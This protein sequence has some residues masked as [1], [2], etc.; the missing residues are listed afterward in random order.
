M[1]CVLQSL[2]YMLLFTYIL[3][4]PSY[5]SE[6]GK[7]QAPVQVPV[8]YYHLSV[9]RLDGDEFPGSKI[10]INLLAKSS[11]TVCI[12]VFR[13]KGNLTGDAGITGIPKGFPNGLRICTLVCFL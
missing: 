8:S 11:A 4:Q 10:L 5:H 1:I 13:I 2:V 12:A 6:A 3:I 7:K 9:N